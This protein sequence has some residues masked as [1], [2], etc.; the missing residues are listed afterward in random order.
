M[1]LKSP[2]TLTLPLPSA[3]KTTIESLKDLSDVPADKV[4][5]RVRIRVRV[6][7]RIRVRVWV[8]VMV[9]VR[10]RVRVGV[11][12]RGR[13]YPANTLSLYIGNTLYIANIYIST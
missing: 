12:V 4:R 9:I 2:T 5:V 1:N 6:R 10:V 8:I 7:V 11:R 3:V 13:G